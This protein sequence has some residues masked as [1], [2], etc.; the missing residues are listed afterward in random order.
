M[1]VIGVG[2]GCRPSVDGK[3]IWPHS[4]DVCLL[5]EEIVAVCCRMDDMR[6]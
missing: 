2:G 5:E 4:A 1:E 3:V 6:K